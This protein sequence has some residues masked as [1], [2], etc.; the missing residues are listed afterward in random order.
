MCIFHRRLKLIIRPRY[1]TLV[2]LII[3]WQLH[4]FEFKPHVPQE[5]IIISRNG[6]KNII[7][8]KSDK[9]TFACIE[10]EFFF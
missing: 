7:K 5:W 2:A 1:V 3:V 4:S 9:C 6:M 8:R 10:S